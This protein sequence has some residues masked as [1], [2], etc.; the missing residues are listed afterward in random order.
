[1]RCGSF[2]LAGFYQSFENSCTRAPPLTQKHPQYKIIPIHTILHVFL[3]PQ[4][5][6]APKI[7]KRKVNAYTIKAQRIVEIVKELKALPHKPNLKQVL[8]DRKCDYNKL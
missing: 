6:C 5:S 2:R 3:Q 4:S 8:D 7:T 1:V